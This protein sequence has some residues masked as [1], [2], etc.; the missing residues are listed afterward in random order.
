MKRCDFQKMCS[1][2]GM[3]DVDDTHRPDESCHHSEEQ[4]KD[5]H[6]HAGLAKPPEDSSQGCPF[7]ALSFQLIVPQRFKPRGK[8]QEHK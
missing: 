8:N 5:G 3:D 1:D 6:Q 2:E 4:S 7:S